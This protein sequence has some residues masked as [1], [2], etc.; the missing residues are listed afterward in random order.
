MGTLLLVDMLPAPPA[1]PYTPLPPDDTPATDAASLAAM[2]EAEAEPAKPLTRRAANYATFRTRDL[3]SA[4]RLWLRVYR[5]TGKAQQASE[6][7]GRY[8]L[9]VMQ[10]GAKDPE[11]RAARE[12]TTA[13]WTALY[14]HGFGTLAPKALKLVEETLDD[15]EVDINLRIK[16]AQWIL[17]A[18][19]IGVEQAAPI[20][21][22]HSG[23]DGGPIPIKQVIVHL[24]GQAPAQIEEHARAREGEGDTGVVDADYAY[25]DEE[26][27]R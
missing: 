18:R 3:A 9:S 13:L 22:E 17:K 11:F 16:I 10:W 12:E 27:E 8:P 5:M 20:S 1:A 23:P 7:V 21:I 15:P 4:K 24:V 26:D 25:V 19:N 2:I 6:A 14:R